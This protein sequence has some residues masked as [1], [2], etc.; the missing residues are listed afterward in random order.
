M[1]FKSLFSIVEAWT[2]HHK[3]APERDNLASL[4]DF[5]KAPTNEKTGLKAYSGKSSGL[6]YDS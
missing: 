3:P 4:G 6:G 2:R 1:P 5:F